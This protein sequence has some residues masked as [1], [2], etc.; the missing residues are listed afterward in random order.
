MDLNLKIKLKR[1]KT[2]KIA[3][4]RSMATPSLS[5]KKMLDK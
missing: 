5:V 4:H 3:V 1:K 2:I